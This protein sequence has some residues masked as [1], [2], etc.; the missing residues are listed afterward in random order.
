MEMNN[1]DKNTHSVSIMIMAYNEVATLKWVVNEIEE[2]LLRYNCPYE[3]VIIDDGST[4][5]TGDLAEEIVKA[6]PHIRV[7]HHDRNLGIGAVKRTGYREARYDIISFFP[8]DGECP[9]SIID[10]FLPLMTDYDMVLGYIPERTDSL[11]ARWLAKAERIMIKLLF[12]KIPEFCGVYMFRRELL[13]KLPLITKGRG[14]M[15]QMEFIIRAYKANY[16]IISIPTP[17]RTRL[18]GRSK[19]N[20]IRCI[21]DNIVQLLRLYWVMDKS[22][23]A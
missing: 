22:N 3:I 5:G 13:T 1:S 7:I 17:M 4:D 20:N 6:N 2:V 14:W 15:I 21:C 23:S 8:A 18:S 16:R 10:Q 11:Y 19:V 9:A 12:G